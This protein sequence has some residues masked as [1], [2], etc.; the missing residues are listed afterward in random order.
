MN[1]IDVS[2]E[3]EVKRDHYTFLDHTPES[4]AMSAQQKFGERVETVYRCGR[5]VFVPIT[6][7]LSQFWTAMDNGV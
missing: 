2:H 5:R 6:I 4:A 1:I 3:A 7:N